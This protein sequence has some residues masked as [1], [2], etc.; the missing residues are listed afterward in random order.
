MVQTPRGKKTYEV[1]E[2]STLHDRVS[3][4]EPPRG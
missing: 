3:A 2:I 1:I 4:E